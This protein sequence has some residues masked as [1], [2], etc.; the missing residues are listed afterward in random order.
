MA[1]ALTFIKYAKWPVILCSAF[2]T[3]IA[4]V[5]ALT[6]QPLYTASSTIF[7]QNQKGLVISKEANGSIPMDVGDIETQ[8]EII[9]S[10]R[11]ADQVLRIVNPELLLPD[12]TQNSEQSWFRSIITSLS[13]WRSTADNSP[14]AQTRLETSKRERERRLVQTGLAVYRPGLS[15]TIEIAYTSRDPELSALLA[16]AY[17]K[18]YIEER[19]NLRNDA[20]RQAT[21]WMEDR[22]D[23]LRTQAEQAFTAAEEYREANVGVRPGSGLTSAQPAETADQRRVK[24]KRLENAA[25]TLQSTYETFFQR[26]AEITQQQSAPGSDAVILNEATVPLSASFPKKKLT[27]LLALIAGAGLGIAVALVRRFV[28]P[29]ID[30]PAQLRSAGIRCV[31][32]VPLADIWQ[33]SG[34]RAIDLSTPTFGQVP[35]LNQGGSLSQYKL[36][37]YMAVLGGA[38]PHFSEAIQ[39]LKVDL[40]LLGLG[41]SIRTLG[42]LGAPSGRH[43]SIIASNLA[44]LMASQDTTLIIDADPENAGVSQLFAPSSRRGIA[45]VISGQI[46]LDDA[47]VKLGGTELTLLPCEPVQARPSLTLNSAAPQKIGDLLEL[48]RARAS[49]VLVNLAPINCASTKSILPRLDA[50]LILADKNNI[51]LGALREVISEIDLRN[52]NVLGVALFEVERGVKPNQRIHVIMSSLRTRSASLRPS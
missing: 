28:S 12:R 7:L 44:F 41:Q 15:Y 30:S 6:A 33:K 20:I 8:I 35:T 23:Q 29:S 19:R 16:N 51:G 46:G 9:R 24:L 25:Q 2:F 37:G 5:Y 4:L 48:A 13:S 52:G 17:A 18:A 10:E 22:V 11:V 45:S 36:D 14:N 43:P 39:S 21:A 3:V 40:E 50:V 49:V 42:I 31:G 27:L 47:L 38:A 1:D 26:L 32:F 34:S